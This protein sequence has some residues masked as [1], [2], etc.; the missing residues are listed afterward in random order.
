MLLSTADRRGHDFHVFRIQPHP[1]GPSL[2][3]V[4]HLYILHRGD[5]TAKVQD[6]VFSL[7]SRWIAISTLRGTTHVF[8]VT[9][10][11]GAAG[12]RTHGSPHVVNR[13]SRFHRSAGLSDARANSPVHSDSSISQISNA[14][15]NPRVPPFPHPLVV[16]P[17]AQLRQPTIL[18]QT[19][20]SQQAQ[21]NVQ[22]RQ[23]LTSLGDEQAKPLRVCATFAKARAW[24][25]EPPGASRDIASL[26]MQRKAV[27]SLFIMASHGALIQYD[28]EPKHNI[29][30]CCD[31]SHGQIILTD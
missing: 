18:G 3:A 13:L 14:Y 8:P 17:L 7:D 30:E 16:L 15:N 4:H 28:L 1:S 11:G 25:L 26:R 31:A 22:T 12:V 2:S 5:T 27:D 10:Y 23:R 24:L 9:P 21:K 29:S 19:N 20:H 6:I